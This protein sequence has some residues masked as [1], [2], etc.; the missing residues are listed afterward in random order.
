MLFLPVIESK[1]MVVKPVNLFSLF[2][3]VRRRIEL[4]QDFEMPTVCT[5]IKV[6]K[7]GQY[8]LATGK[9]LFGYD[10]HT[11]H[12]RKCHGEKSHFFLLP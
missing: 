7:D 6:S 8:I 5:T 12:S 10:L 11:F 4:I 2:V 9:H 1:H 3:D